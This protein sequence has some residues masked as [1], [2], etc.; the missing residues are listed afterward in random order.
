[1][2][3]LAVPSRLVAGGPREALRRL[4]EELERA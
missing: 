2:L 3:M 4:A 1:N